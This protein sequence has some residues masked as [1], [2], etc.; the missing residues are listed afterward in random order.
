[1]D[2]G[3]SHFMSD[4]RV[5]FACLHPKDIQQ[6]MIMM[7]IAIFRFEYPTGMTRVPI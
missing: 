4:D 1:M 2:A 7:T 6:L 3:S 5:C